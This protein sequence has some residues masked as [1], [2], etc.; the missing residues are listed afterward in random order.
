MKEIFWM[1]EEEEIEEE[2]DIVLDDGEEHPATNR[3]SNVSMV[4]DLD[5][6]TSALKVIVLDG[7]R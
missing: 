7:V 1:E 3:S 4:I 6:Q 5:E 2:V